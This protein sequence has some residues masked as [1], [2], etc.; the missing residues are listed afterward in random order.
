MDSALGRALHQAIRIL[1]H[2]GSS[3]YASSCGSIGCSLSRV[4]KTLWPGCSRRSAGRSDTGP[5]APLF[6]IVSNLHDR[7][8]WNVCH[9]AD[10]LSMPESVRRAE[11]SSHRLMVALRCVDECRR[12]YRAA[13]SVAGCFGDGAFSSMV[14]TSPQGYKAGGSVS[15]ATKSLPDP[16]MSAL[17]RPS[18]LPIHL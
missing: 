12:R 16:H 13:D 11:R 17:V 9:S 2:S 10:T 6:A 1:V 15:M 3:L 4:I 8:S 7:H 18:A 5:L 14:S